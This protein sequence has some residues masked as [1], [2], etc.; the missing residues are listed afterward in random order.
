MANIYAAAILRLLD[1]TTADV[2]HPLELREQATYIKASYTTHRDTYRLMA[3]VSALFNSG[4][5]LHPSH[6]TQ[7]PDGNAHLPVQRLGPVLHAI[8]TVHGVSPD[9]PDFEGH[10]I[11]LFSK[12]DPAIRNAAVGLTRYHL[13]RHL[14]ALER[15]ANEHLARLTRQ[16][17]YHYIFRAGLTQYY[18]TKAVADCLIFLRRDHRGVAYRV[19]AQR[20]CY[21]ALEQFPTLT[22]REKNW[23]IAF[24]RAAPED[25]H[26]F[27]NWLTVNRAHYRAMKICLPMLEAI[28]FGHLGACTL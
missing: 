14:I 7:A 20:L 26:R 12:L 9:V 2:N 27:W 6:R 13:D 15:V 24:V 28:Q 23:L 16:Y 10:P 21:E 19:N 17:G 11:E 25:V 3:Q 5:L 4:N 1:T 22:A 18:Q 8:G